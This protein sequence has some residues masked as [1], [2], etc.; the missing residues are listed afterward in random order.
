MNS[1]QA[2]LL[3][4]DSDVELPVPLRE[5]FKP[6]LKI[7][8][9]NLTVGTFHNGY[10][11]QDEENA[12]VF[13]G[14]E[15]DLIAGRIYDE[16]YF[17][18]ENCTTIYYDFMK[19]FPKGRLQSYLLGVLM[20]TLLR[21]RGFLVLHACGVAKDG[22]AVAFV[23]ESGWGKSTL[24]EYFCQRGY[25]LLSDDVMAVQVGQEGQ[26]EVLPSYPQIR[27]RPEAGRYLRRDFDDLPEVK[28]TAGKRFTTPERFPDRPLPL[29]K[30]Y[31]M[32]PGYTT[33]NAVEPMPARR[34]LLRLIQHTRATNLIKAPAFQARLLRQCEQ[35]IRHVPVERLCRVKDLRRLHEIYELV[36]QDLHQRQDDEESGTRSLHSTLAA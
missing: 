26:A 7:Q 27:L 6:D 9:R 2:Y 14:N 31:L 22:Q 10:G 20:A 15:G 36:E 4:I 24:A 29:H 13:V 18:V 1:Y 23:G 21:Q 28:A 33:E 25:T 17:V 3:Y 35:L 32:D 19:S 34:A 16:L 11:L 12:D 5:G 30:L 8:R